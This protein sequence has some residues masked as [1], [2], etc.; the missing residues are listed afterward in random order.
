VQSSGDTADESV[1]RESL[2]RG[3]QVGRFVVLGLVGRGGMGDVYAAHDPELD[4]KVA[5]KLLRGRANRGPTAEGRARLMREA[6]AIAKV[7]HPNVVVIYDVGTFDGRVFIAMEFIEGAT[8]GY[9]MQFQ[10]RTLSEILEVFVA[11]GRGLES[12]HEKELVHRDFKPDNVM[13]GKDGQVRVMDFGLARLAIDREKSSSEG[14]GGSPLLSMAELDEDPMSTRILAQATPNWPLGTT[15]PWEDITRAGAIVG[16][17][18]YMAPEQFQGAAT[19][20][21]TDQFSFCVALYE[22]LYS[23]RPF[24]AQNFQELTTNVLTGQIRP[25]PEGS[26]VPAS[27]RRALLRGLSTRPEDRFPSMN[28]LLAQ[29]QQEPAWSGVRRF[30]VGAAAKLAGVWEAPEVGHDGEAE[31]KAAVR[32]AFLATGKPYAAAAF[33]ATSRILDRFA[34]RWT[35]LYVDACEATHVRGDQSPEILDLRMMALG[36]ALEDLRALC[37]QLRQATPDT[38]EN[39]VNAAT[40]LGTLERCADVKLLRAI[41]RPPED[42]ATRAEVEELRVRLAGVRALAR[43]GRVSEGLKAAVAL[44]RDARRVGYAPL[45]AEVL[46]ICGMMRFEVSDVDEATRTVEDAA[47]TAELCR[48]DEVAAEA[49][50]SLVYMTGHVQS[51]FDAGEIWSRHAETVLRRIGGHDLV[52]GWL[53]NNR[54]AMRATQGRLREAIED[55]HQAIGAK[56]KAL[57]PDDADVGSSVGNTAIYLDELGETEQAVEFTERAVRIM[58]GAL[59][60]DHPKVA[61][62]LANLAELRNRLGRFEEARVPAERA[63]AIF[64]RET[65][66]EGIYVTYP[67]AALGLSHLGAGRFR[68]AV[69]PLAR[70][71]RIRDAREKVLAKL[72]E[73]HFALARALG[74]AGEDLAA[75]RALA[76]R[77]RNEYREAPATPATA[78]ELDQIERWLA[79]LPELAGPTPPADPR[80]AEPAAR[81]PNR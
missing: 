8:L 26:V 35:D 4:R 58:E 53:F 69:P 48:H 13:V 57:G 11:A 18:A 17:P 28:A 21:R 60:Q 73:V 80:P 44:E 67:L 15:T 64:E 43:L 2:A 24:A 77:A 1:A 61:I 12:A 52:R 51:R 36:D 39:A 72:G 22:A 42:A 46:F 79:G 78:R 66:P 81:S 5:I 40:A 30:A 49:A 59:G 3:V 45:L 10:P 50:A 20:A 75:A 41:V 56:E 38:V 34:R 70:A 6:Q 74:G 14:P 65:D 71:V 9:W 31:A 23:V 37:H 54:G 63:L 68:E 27:I 32:R 76:L 25:E 33:E 29:L 47:W 55:M 19:D 62:Q 7:S 16:T